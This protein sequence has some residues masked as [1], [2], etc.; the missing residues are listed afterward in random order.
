MNR[1][2]SARI[3]PTRLPGICATTAAMKPAEIANCRLN[4]APGSGRCHY[5]DPFPCTRFRA[6]QLSR[7]NMTDIPRPKSTVTAGAA[8][9]QR[10]KSPT[11]IGNWELI[12]PLSVGPTTRTFL[13]R[14]AGTSMP[15]GYVAKLLTEGDADRQ[16]GLKL[17]RREVIVGRKVCHAH[18][19][20]VL[21]AHIHEPPYCIV[22]PRLAGTTVREQLDARGRIAI[23]DALWIARQV[24]E[25]LAA[26]H[27]EGWLHSD[28]KPDNIL[29]APDGHVTLLD[30]GFAR[31]FDEIGSA[32]DRCVMGTYNYIAPEMV[33]STMAADACSDI[34]SLGVT[35]YET[36]TGQLPLVGK[37]LAEMATQHRQTTPECIRRV[38]P[39]TPEPV[40]RLVHRMLAKQPVRRPQTAEEVVRRLVGLEIETFAQRRTA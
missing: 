18:L 40:G 38:V 28:I 13:A 31:S 32:V 10:P 36:I 22:M 3:S 23:P 20:S 1:R 2:V 15:C 26:L 27:R 37:T 11:I 21:D 29:V 9:L 4:F 25:A 17:L 19:V 24:A 16:L 30:L 5:L 14:P 7:D 12:E 34:Y 6:L 33:T 8:H 39:E 35:L